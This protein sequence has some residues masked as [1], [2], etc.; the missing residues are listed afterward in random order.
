MT[1]EQK[2]HQKKINALKK[3]LASDN[4]KKNIGSHK[5]RARRR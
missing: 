4:E 5:R 3:A 2:K 1:E